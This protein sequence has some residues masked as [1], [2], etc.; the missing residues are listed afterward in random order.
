VLSHKFS[1]IR[2]EEVSKYHSY[3]CF[4]LLVAISVV[5]T[6]QRS[7]ISYM[8]AI[9][10]TPEFAYAE[11]ST[12]SIRIAI[13]NFDAKN[14][15]LM[16]G[17]TFTIIYAFM[18]LFTGAASDVLNRKNLL[19]GSCFCWCLCIYLCSFTHDFW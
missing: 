16:V 11:N 18:V 15:E 9:Q 8:Y 17:D 6:V 3:W 5:N 4:I 12:Y 13:E 2:Y 1:A 7:T 14:Y 19:C 10:N